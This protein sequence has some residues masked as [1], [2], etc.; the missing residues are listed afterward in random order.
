ME[1][2]YLKPAGRPNDLFVS[3]IW[4]GPI[5]SNNAKSKVR[6]SHMYGDYGDSNA[7]VQESD[8]ALN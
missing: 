1:S 4:N 8:S 3:E 6:A 7:G 2:R 5:I